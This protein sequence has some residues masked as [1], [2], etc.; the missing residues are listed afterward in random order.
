MRGYLGFS[1]FGKDEIWTR[2]PDTS[3]ARS[4]RPSSRNI[5]RRRRRAMKQPPQ[6]RPGARAR[7]HRARRAPRDRRAAM[8][9]ARRAGACA[10]ASQQ[11]DPRS[12]PGSAIP[13]AKSLRARAP[14]A[15]PRPRPAAPRPP[16]RRGL[17]RWDARR[18]HT[19]PTEP[20]RSR[21]GCRPAAA[22]TAGPADR[23]SPRSSC[24]WRR[25]SSARA[26]DRRD[27]RRRCGRTASA[28]WRR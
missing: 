23:S 4:I 9:P 8:A 14:A 12:A 16:S 28:G 27:I 2:L 26:A 21:H 13:A 6:E 10:D 7:W 20:P 17:R 19:P 15:A 24:H 25:G 11:H 5:C 1:L 3:I 18:R 22:T